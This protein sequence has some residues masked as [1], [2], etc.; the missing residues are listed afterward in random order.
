MG[1]AGLAQADRK[2]DPREAGLVDYQDMNGDGFPD[3]ITP[4]SV[5]YTTQRGAYRPGGVNPGEL[6]VTNQDLTFAIS[7]GIEGGLVDIKANAKGKTNATQ[8]GAAGKGGD[9]EDSGGGISLS[10]STSAELDQPQRLEREPRR[11]VQSEPPVLRRAQR[12]QLVRR[13][14]GLP[15][16]TAPIQ[17]GLADVNGE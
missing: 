2:P 9:A 12:D 17:L 5:T 4:S 14:R 8:G 6:A 3:I 7:A 16:D 11:H 1:P 13:H 10:A 15:G